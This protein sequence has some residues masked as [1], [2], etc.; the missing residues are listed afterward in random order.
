M[1]AA[2]LSGVDDPAALLLADRQRGVAGCVVVPVL[3][4]ERPLLVEVQG[5]VAPLNKETP[6]APVGR[7]RGSTT[8]RLA[9]LLAVLDRRA[10]IKLNNADVYASAVGGVR[11]TEP[12]TDLAVALALASAHTN[13]A[14]PDDL[15]VCGEVGLAGEVRQVRHTERRLAEA[16]RLGFTRA[17]VP[18]SGPE[19][20]DGIELLKV[21]SVAEAI[22]VTRLRRS[23]GN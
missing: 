9:L 16:A 17:V 23:S 21:H 2:G 1:T 5:L 11:V 22:A 19:R 7:R 14:L 15:V 6:I 18:A 12:A 3:E 4:G 13:C 10:N 8:R 20:V